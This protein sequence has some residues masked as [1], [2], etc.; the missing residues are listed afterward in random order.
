MENIS[1]G[2]PAQSVSRETAPL[3]V[4]PPRGGLFCG[5]ES[6]ST[7]LSHLFF[8]YCFDYSIFHPPSRCWRRICAPRELKSRTVFIGGRYQCYEKQKNLVKNE[9]RNQVR[10]FSLSKLLMIHPLTVF[11]C[12]HFCRNTISSP[13]CRWC[14]SSSFVSSSTFTFS[15]WRCRSLFPT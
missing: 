9:I 12:W 14:C 10:R 4:K 8:C 1:Q 3:I 15:S 2:T 11:C 13:S 6:S 5:F 7:F